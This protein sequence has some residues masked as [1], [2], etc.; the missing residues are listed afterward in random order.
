MT[1]STLYSFLFWGTAQSL[2]WA[3]LYGV[4]LVLALR[5][6]GRHGAWWAVGGFGMLVACA[7]ARLIGSLWQAYLF[8]DTATSSMGGAFALLRLWNAT[9]S[10]LALFGHGAVLVALVKA[11]RAADRGPVEWPDAPLDE[12]LT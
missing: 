7:V 10:F 6:R 3:I 2:P 8:V 5:L 4:G 11:W 1:E 9:F 12:P